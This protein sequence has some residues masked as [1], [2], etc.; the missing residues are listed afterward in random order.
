MLG[1]CTVSVLLISA[2]CL[3]FTSVSAPDV[4]KSWA[5]PRAKTPETITGSNSPSRATR[6]Q[7]D[8]R[9]TTNKRNSRLKPIPDIQDD[10]LIFSDDEQLGLESNSK[11]KHPP[12]SLKAPAI[13]DFADWDNGKPLTKQQRKN[14]MSLKSN[15]ERSREMNKIRNQRKLRELDLKGGVAQALGG[16]KDCS[17]TRKSTSTASSKG[18]SPAVDAPAT[19][20]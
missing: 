1:G 7:P 4:R 14:I 11:P 13:D 12:K 2:I 9:I 3:L 17:T 20:R 6:I 10:E 8:N 18:S 5:L 16:L 15:Y 19:R